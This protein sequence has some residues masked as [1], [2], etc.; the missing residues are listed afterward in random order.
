[1]SKEMYSEISQLSEE[2]NNKDF[3]QKGNKEKIFKDTL[4]AINKYKGEDKMKKSN[5]NKKLIMKVA[6][7]ALVC[8]L[9]IT[10]MR[11][12]FAQ[13][14]VD[15]IVKT[16]TLG[17]VTVFQ[18]E[19][20]LAKIFIMPEIVK[21]KIFDKD[22]NAIEE[23]VE[24]QFEKIYTAEGDEIGEID[25]ETGKIMTIDQ[26]EKMLEEGSLIVKDID[27]L[28]NYTCFEVILPSYLPE[29]YEFD[30]ASFF[31]DEDGIVDNSKYI[32][33]YFTNSK[34]GE[35]IYMQQRFADKETAYE[36]GGSKVEE[37]KINGADGVIY[38]NNL[39]WEDKGVIYMLN[40]RT[41][42]RNELIK[43]AES[44]NK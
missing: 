38:D 6:S 5:K 8:I 43:V 42:D 18:D 10:S 36:A 41:I 7:I 20:N 30:K 13:G 11:T 40:G 22:G 28:N 21:G 33:L 3:S 23:F 1:M 32:A 19:A 4:K 26:Q 31:K 2:L 24:G 39:D 9:G 29:G 27:K 37:I 16:I 14:L 25:M 17:H 15:K 44:F 12:S 34:T 35:Y